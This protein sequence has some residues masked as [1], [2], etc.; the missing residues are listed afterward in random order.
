MR[1]LWLPIRITAIYSLV[2]AVLMGG[3]FYMFRKT[4]GLNL[5]KNIMGN[6]VAAKTILRAIEFEQRTA[7]LAHR[8][9]RVRAIV[10]AMATKHGGEMALLDGRGA[11][12]HST[13]AQPSLWSQD[14]VK[15]VPI[16]KRTCGVTPR[17]PFTAFVA[18]RGSGGERS[19]LALTNEVPSLRSGQRVFISGLALIGLIGLLGVFAF[20]LYITRPLRRMSGSMDRI[21]GGELDHRVW[22]KGR[23]EVAHMGE[24]F[25]AMADRVELMVRNQRELLAGVSHELRSPLSRMKLSLE[26]LLQTG[27]DEKRV[28]SLDGEVDALEKLVDE[29]MVISRL[30]LATASLKLEL[31]E[32]QELVTR[33]WQR[34]A[35]AA[36]EQQIR[37]ELDLAPGASQIMVDRELTIRLLGNLLENA[38]RHGGGEVVKVSTRPQ[39]GRVEVVVS[40]QGQGVPPEALRSLFEPF[41]RVD[42]SRSRRTGGTGVGLMIVRRAIETHGGQVRAEILPEGGLAVIF[43][44]PGGQAER[45]TARNLSPVRS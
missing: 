29:L 33:S 9:P 27:A 19:T 28:S 2:L 40:D 38:V 31:S 43:D 36:E 10:R 15:R 25:N 14:E 26:L 41:Y 12:I 32:V 30:D 44:L 18:T 17:P 24:S 39:N 42:S 16:G 5:R 35:A 8:S 11:V 21:A 6:L 7:G 3:A 45:P 1:S 34:V 22:V 23:D 20:S 4:V 37:L 13:S